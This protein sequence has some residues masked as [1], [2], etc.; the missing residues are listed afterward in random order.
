VLEYKGLAFESVDLKSP[1]DLKK[2]NKVTGKMRTQGMGRLPYDVVMRETAG[3]LDAL[4]ELLGARP[5]FHMDRPGAADF[6]LYGQLVF[7]SG[8]ATPDFATLLADR[9]A[10]TDFVKR[11]ADAKS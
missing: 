9:P 4:V 6:A 1:G 5:Y 2:W 8:E 10:L 7:A 3:L 11:V